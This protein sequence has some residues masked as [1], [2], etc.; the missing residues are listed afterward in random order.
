MKLLIEIEMDNSAFH[1]DN[2]TEVARLLKKFAAHVN[3]DSIDGHFDYTFIDSNGV[4]VGKAL[5]EGDGTKHEIEFIGPEG[6]IV[7]F[8]FREEKHDEPISVYC[9]DENTIDLIADSS[10]QGIKASKWTKETVSGRYSIA[11]PAVVKAVLEEVKAMNYAAH[12][13]EADWHKTGKW[14]A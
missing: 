13:E 4:K 10:A 5:V 3:D 12:G 9:N 8:V 7:T 2:G 6:E 14:P 1:P 11:D